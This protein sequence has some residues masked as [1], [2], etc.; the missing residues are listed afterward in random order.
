MGGG[1]VLSPSIPMPMLEAYI[2]SAQR[3]RDL[4]AGADIFISNH[5][6]LE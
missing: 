1:T 5:T 6:M 2:K 3:F 4:A